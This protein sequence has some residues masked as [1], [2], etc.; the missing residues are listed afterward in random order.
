MALDSVSTASTPITPACNLITHAAR[1]SRKKP[2]P[3]STQV[4]TFSSH[5]PPCFFQEAIPHA[6]QP[7]SGPRSLHMHIPKSRAGMHVHPE[8]PRPEGQPRQIRD[9]QHLRQH[10]RHGK[11]HEHAHGQHRIRPRMQPY[12]AALRSILYTS[13]RNHLRSGSD[14][15]RTYHNAKIPPTQIRQRDFVISGQRSVLLSFNYFRFFKALMIRVAK[16]SVG[17]I[18]R[19]F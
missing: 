10:Y 19:I 9:R 6:L 2:A 14:G 8:A 17:S 15:H 1:Q 3:F 18:S 11:R 13:H 5:V 12:E 4:P 7:L 16:S